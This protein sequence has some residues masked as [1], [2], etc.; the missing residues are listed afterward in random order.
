MRAAICTRVST[1][2]QVNGTSLDTQMDECHSYARS[3]GLKVVG[4]YVDG[5][6][7]GKYANRPSLDRLMADCRGGLIDVVIVSKHD[8]FGRSFRHTVVLIG[9]LEEM[10][11]EFVSIAERIDDTPAG[12]FQR[13]VLLSVSEFE[14]ERILERTVAGIERTAL[15]G[16]WPNGGIPFGW[17]IFRDERSRSKVEIDP[18][19]AA[20]WE[21][22]AEALIDR[23]LSTLALARELNAAGVRTRKGRTWS[24]SSVNKLVRDAHALDGNWVYRR[25]GRRWAKPGDG[26]PI[27]ISLPP[28]LT[29]E[30]FA[31]LQAAIGRPNRTRKPVKTLSLLSGR[32]VSSC[33]SQMWVM[34]KH[35]GVRFYRCRAKFA[36]DGGGGA[37]VANCGCRNIDANAIEEHVWTAVAEALSDPSALVGLAADQ[38]ATAAAS[39][40]ISTDDVAALDRRIARL[41]KAASTAL[42]DALAQGIDMAVAAGAVKAIQTGLTE[43]RDRRQQV[44]AWAATAAELSGRAKTINEIATE[45]NAALALRPFDDAH[46]RVLDALDVTV[47]ATD[48]TVCEACGG[49][50]RATGAGRGRICDPCAGHGH[51]PVLA[52]QGHLPRLAGGEALWPVTFAGRSS[53]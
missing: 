39:A 25:E 8:R 49:S 44:A 12:R 42:A 6:V 27:P 34:T 50:G 43:A 7:S 30:R 11:I 5:G 47:C 17:R 46:R 15:E 14:R 45:T 28:I 9:E 3:R 1:A 35:S 32:L 31:A 20:V 26:P 10:G 2:E 41:E 51:F 13:N 4:E 36:A 21:R 48:W 22:I 37:R 33:G 18:V 16:R 24:A 53:A 40:G 23:G 38:A 29:G 52:I 19:E